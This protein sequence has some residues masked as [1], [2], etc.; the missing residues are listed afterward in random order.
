MQHVEIVIDFVAAVRAVALSHAAAH[1]VDLT[2]KTALTEAFGG[3]AVRPW[4]VLR[5]SGPTVTVVG[6]SQLDADALRERLS[7]ATPALRNAVIGVA[8]APVTLRQGQFVRFSVRLTPVI[9]VT[10]K[11]ETDAFLLSPAGSNRGQIYGDYLAKRLQGATVNA[12]QMVRFRLEK[13]TRPHRGEKPTPSG[14]G[15]RTVPD[16]VLE[17]VLTV[18]DPAAFAETLATGVGRQRAY[19]R[20][21]IRLEPVALERAA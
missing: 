13:I 19:G 15:S 3:P 14:F 4:S 18:N 21:F 2:I 9:N 5:Q 11:R 20:G 12:V 16:A 1:D 7:L 8:S 10:G 6:Y 17:G